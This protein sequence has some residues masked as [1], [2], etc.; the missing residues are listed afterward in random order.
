MRAAWIVVALFVVVMGPGACTA[1]TGDAPMVSS[2]DELKAVA[3]QILS[4][5]EYQRQMRGAGQVPVTQR[6][7]EALFGWLRG[8]L[9]QPLFEGLQRAHPVAFWVLVAGLIGLLGLLLF[10]FAV[11]LRSSLRATPRKVGEVS[12]APDSK[13]GPQ[14]LVA[15]A[16][17]AAAA[18]RYREA[19]RCVYRA[20]LSRLDAEGLISYDQTKTNWE[21]LNTIRSIE[22]LYKPFA[23]LTMLFDR[24]WYGLEPANVNDYQRCRRLWS[25]ATVQHAP[26]SKGASRW[27]AGGVSR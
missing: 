24:K 12:A 16:E 13:P 7:W 10:H 22:A 21:Y 23:E 27:A 14:D 18:G 2:T 15:E 8:I 3:Q 5:A 17:Q 20:L 25:E 19:I 6:L 11:I 26:G 9:S 1:Q 4:G